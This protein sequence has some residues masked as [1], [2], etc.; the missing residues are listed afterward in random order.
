M[1]SSGPILFEEE[2]RF[3]RNKLAWIVAVILAS[4]LFVMTRSLVTTWAEIRRQPILVM[5][6]VVLAY[7]LIVAIFVVL[8][9]SRLKTRVEPDGLFV[10]FLPFHLKE[11]CIPAS[12]I[13]TWEAITYQPILEYGG[14]GIRYGAKS[15]AYNVHDNR[16][17]LLKRHN[18]RPLLIGSQNP[19]GLASALSILKSQASIHP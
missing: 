7:G 13:A 16:G 5:A 9:T 18:N 4:A 19:D 1:K 3:I 15:N 11:R 17:V 10:R 2:Q 14:W 6:L 12:D 8:I